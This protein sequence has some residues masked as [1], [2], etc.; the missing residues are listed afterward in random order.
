MARNSDPVSVTLALDAR[1][2]AYHGGGI[3]QHVE[4][5]LVGLAELAPEERLWVLRHRRSRFGDAWRRPWAAPIDGAPAGGSAAGWTT[6]WLWTP[7]HF[8]W[9]GWTLAAEVARTGAT[10]LHCPDVVL[11]ARWRG[12]GVATVHDLAF[13]RRPELLTAASRR[14][15]GGVHGSVRRAARVIAVSEHTRRE[16]LALTPVDPGKV[17]VIPNAVHLY[18]AHADGQRIEDDVVARYGLSRPFILFVSTIEPRKNVGTLLAAYRRLLD[19]GREVG[20]ALAGADGWHSAPV[21]EAARHLGLEDRA[22]FLGHVPEADLAALYRSAAVLAH[23]ALD[24]GF[25]MT[26]LEAMASGTPVV[27]S[28]AGSLPELVGEAGLTVPA[29][30]AAAWAEA[31]GAVLD[32]PDLAARLAAAGRA[33]AAGYTVRRMAEATLAVYRAVLAERRTA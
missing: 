25:G 29:E 10:L 32:R 1:L 4:R 18:Q 28:E 22:R 12:A 5:L 19:D 13:L 11:P 20:L 15:Y 9:E 23:P 6:R 16:L 24:E 30:D 8:R 7:P 31:L 2:T 3:A 17:V 33:R 27:V 21:Y 14:Y 26:P